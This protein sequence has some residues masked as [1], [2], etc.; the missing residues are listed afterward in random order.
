M[1]NVVFSCAKIKFF[2]GW[3][4]ERARRTTPLTSGTEGKPLRPTCRSIVLNTAIFRAASMV[5]ALC[6]FSDICCFCLRKKVSIA[7]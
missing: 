4:F 7:R 3:G 5:F 6:N 2:N 1:G